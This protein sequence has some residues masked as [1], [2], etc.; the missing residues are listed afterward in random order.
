MRLARHRRGLQ[1]HWLVIPFVG[2]A[3]CLCALAVSFGG[4][5]RFD[6]FG[7]FS[8]GFTGLCLLMA[9]ASFAPA[10]VMTLWGAIY[11]PIS[12]FWLAPALDAGFELVGG[13][14]LLAVIGAVLYG[15]TAAVLFTLWQ[16]IY[17]RWSLQPLFVSLG[18]AVAFGL[19][20]VLAEWIA[21]IAGLVLAP[22]GLLAVY[23][24]HS[25]LVAGLGV[26][27]AG[28]V[29]VG[30]A[31]CVVFSFAYRPAISACI[32][33]LV[34]L[35]GLMSG[36][37]R[38]ALPAILISA[39]SHDPDPRGKWTPDGSVQVYDALVQ[40]SGGNDADLVIWPENAVTVT[41][42][43]D[44]IVDAPPLGERAHL[45]GMTRYAGPDGPALVNSAVLLEDG[46]VQASDKVHLVP[47]IERSM[48]FFS[49]SDLITGTRRILTLAN[50]IRILPLL[51]Y[52]AAFP[53]PDR[54]L[55]DT[56]DIIIVL[57]AETGFWQRM[58][59][60][61]AA[62]HA[63]ARELETGIRVVRVSD[64]R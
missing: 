58:T 62:R 18:R 19:S 30:L 7:S 6:V 24:G 33:A 40:A 3:A 64:R 59:G 5:G 63:R 45:F 61:I 52:E 1:D 48:P 43:L 49:Q 32:F 12:G 37:E 60:A 39:I 31:A 47:V 22:I 41:F 56:P 55:D 50:G 11:V 53:V 38:P 4:D 25:W 34:L 13:F 57:A 2:L 42:D 46:Q 14:V 44:Q 28:G 20:V 15:W 36:P 23:G 51:C 27:S 29:L 16:I 54:D 10:R 9:A 21:A 26:F 35:L 8:L 17:L